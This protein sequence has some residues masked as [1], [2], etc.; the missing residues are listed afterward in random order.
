MAINRVFMIFALA[1]LVLPAIAMELSDSSQIHGFASQGY[2]QSSDNRFMGDSPSGSL[3]FTE[4]GVNASVMLSNNLRASGQLLVRRAGDMYDG[5]PD[6]DYGLLDYTVTANESICSGVL[7]GRF[8]NPL[9]FYN[10]TRDVA[11]TRPSVFLP[12]SIYFDKVRNFILSNDG[13][14]CYSEWFGMQDSFNLQLGFGRSPI[15]E[16]VKY[17]YFGGNPVTG[18][19]LEGDLEADGVTWVGRLLYEL[20]GGQWRFALSGAEGN[21]LFKNS[22][23][24]AGLGEYPG[25]GEVRLEYYLASAQYNAEQWSLTAEWMREPIYWSEFPEGSPQNHSVTA[26]GYYMQGEYRLEKDWQLFV[27]YEAGFANRNDKDGKQASAATGG[28]VPAYDFYSK[29]WIGGFRWDLNSN[30]MLRSEL[31]AKQGTFTLS[32]RENPDKSKLVKNWNLFALL[33]SYRF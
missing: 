33:L 22:G 3:D 18:E 17:A 13:L 21:T 15:D 11:F 9:G 30:W 23:S 14:Q 25:N 28:A 1:F 7:L 24:I 10:D 6:L 29:D 2:V 5:S 16:N 32:A 4:L 8:K 27:R 19:E 26:E 20:N 31:H 12:Q